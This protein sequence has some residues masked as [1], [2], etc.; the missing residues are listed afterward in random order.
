MSET[1]SESLN[2]K[3]TVTT[4]AATSSVGHSE[5]SVAE[6]TPEPLLTASQEEY[7]LN[8]LSKSNTQRTVNNFC[9]CTFNFSS[10]LSEIVLKLIHK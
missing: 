7:I 5:I 8:D 9:N 6:N 10:E 4:I 3:K 1:L 2:N